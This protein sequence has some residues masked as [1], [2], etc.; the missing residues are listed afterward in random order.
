MSDWY[1]TD[2]LNFSIFEMQCKCGCGRAEM[3]PHFMALL[4]AIRDD[5]GPM[6]ISSGYRCSDHNIRV[7]RSDVKGPHTTGRAVDVMICG[8]RAYQLIGV[9][10]DQGVTGLGIAQKGPRT[11]RFVHLDN[12]QTD[13][14][15]GP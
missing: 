1:P 13:E 12:L 3:D 2:L 5:V 9:A 14:T 6:V 15:P 4:Q 10:Q 8:A 7:S 11:G